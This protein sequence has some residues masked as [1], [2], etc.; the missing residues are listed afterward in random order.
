MMSNP[1]V[2]CVAALRASTELF[3]KAGMERLR[4]KSLKLTAYLE[5]LIDS[6]L[7]PEHV[8]IITP[9]DAEQRGCQLSLVFK[10]DMQRVHA[11]ISAQGVICDIR[12]PSVMRIA[13]TPLY[14]TFR[15]VFD[16]VK[17]LKATLGELGTQ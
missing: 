4:A 9:R 14:N 3:A 11:A 7:G 16:F 12:K 10:R 15:D 13:P 2:L 1:P 8:E 5:L 17:L 6:Q